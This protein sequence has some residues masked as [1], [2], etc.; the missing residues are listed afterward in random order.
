MKTDRFPLTLSQIDIYFNQLHNPDNPLYNV[1]GYIRLPA[2]DRIRLS[3]AHAS[4]VRSHDAFGVRISPDID[5]VSQY[6]SEVRT[7]KLQFLDLSAESNSIEAAQNYVND[8]FET[9]M[10][11]TE[12]ELFRAW[13]LK[14]A[15]DEYWYV[16]LAHHLCMDGFGFAN[17][18][19]ELGLLYDNEQNELRQPISIKEL[20]LDDISYMEG[21]RYKKDK[22]YWSAKKIDRKEDYFPIKP[23]VV[24]NKSIRS[25]RIT[26]RL[27]IQQVAQV[28]NLAE[29]LNVGIHVIYLS[30][31]AIYLGRMYGLREVIIGIPVH[32]RRGFAQKN[33]LGVMANITPLKVVVEL[34]QPFDS[35]VKY[36]SDLQKRDY[37]HQRYPMGHISRDS[38]VGHDIGGLYKSVFNYLAL[39]SELNIG[40]SDCELVYCPHNH[41]KNPLMFTLWRYAA[42]D[43]FVH[44]D[45]NH[46]YLSSAEIENLW[47]CLEQA[48]ISVSAND[49]LPLSEIEFLNAESLSIL[50][51]YSIAPKIPCNTFLEI[52][53]S[54]DY[55]AKNTPREIAV[56]SKGEQLTYEQL[57]IQSDMLASQLYE[58]GLKDNEAVG[59]CLSRDLTLPVA[60]L[61]VLKAGAAYVALD[62]AY[63]I[64]RL[65]YIVNDASIRFVISRPSISVVYQLG[66]DTILNP[67]DLDSK[68]A[69]S[70]DK[71]PAATYHLERSYKANNLAY[72]L[73]TSGSTGYPKGVLIEHKSVIALLEW[74][75]S[76]FS[77]NE[78]RDVLCS[79]SIN[80][81]LFVF[82]FWAALGTGNQLT[83]VDNLFDILEFTNLTPTLIN[84]VP[85]AIAAVV[86][87]TM[88]METVATVNI[89][90]EPLKRSLVNTLFERSRAS[91]ILNLYGPSEDTTYSTFAVF[92]NKLEVEP[93]IG[94]PIANGEA[95][96]I[97]NGGQ[98]CPVGV[99]GELFLSG[100]GLARGYLNKPDL[101]YEKFVDV[102]LLGQSRRCYKTGDLA[103]WNSDGQ[104]EFLG[105]VDHQVKIRGY[106]IELGDID[107]VLQR[108]DLVSDIV[109]VAVD[110]ASKLVTYFVPRSKVDSDYAIDAELRKLVEQYLPAYMMPAFFFRLNSLPLTPN[111][112][113]DRKALPA[114]DLSSS[115]GSTG[116]KPR[117][118][119]ENLIASSWSKVLGIPLDT[120][121]IDKDFFEAGGD[122]IIALQFVAKCK[123][124]GLQINLQDIFRRKTIRKLAALATKKQAFES[125]ASLPSEGEQQLLPIQ[126]LLFRD[127][128]HS[129]RSF[130]HYVTLK[131][132]VPVTLAKIKRIVNLLIGMHDVFRLDFVNDDK[133]WSSRYLPTEEIDVDSHIAFYQITPPLAGGDKRQRIAK[134]IKEQNHAVDLLR[135]NL[136]KFVLI[137][138]ARHS[139]LSIICHHLIVDGVSWRILT[140]DIEQILQNNELNDIVK[141]YQISTYQSWAELLWGDKSSAI[142]LAEKPYWISQLDSAIV[143]MHCAQP[144]RSTKHLSTRKHRWRMPLEQASSVFAVVFERFRCEAHHLLLAAILL[145]LHRWSSQSAFCVGL[146]SH[147]RNSL[148]DNEYE[149]STIVGWFTSFHKHVL[150]LPDC[151]QYEDVL[152]YTKEVLRK[153]PNGGIGYGVLTEIIKDEEFR[154]LDAETPVDLLFNYLGRMDQAFARSTEI[155]LDADLSGYY[156]D[157]QRNRDCLLGFN[158]M[159]AGGEL[160]FDID[161]SSEEFSEQDVKCIADEFSNVL[162]EFGSLGLAKDLPRYSPSDFPA[163]RVN[164]TQLDYWVEEYGN[165]SDI[166]PATKTQKGMLYHSS[167]DAGAYITQIV[168]RFSKDL[169]PALFKNAWND[170]VKKYAVFR[171]RFSVDY[172]NQIVL[173]EDDVCWEEVCD[174]SNSIAA[175][176]ILH[177]DKKSIEDGSITPLVRFTLVQK[178]DCWEFF[179]TFHHAILDGWSVALVLSDL[180]LFYRDYKNERVPKLTEKYSYKNI[181][182]WLNARSTADSVAYWKKQLNQFE[183]PSTFSFEKPIR[184]TSTAAISDEV[185]I[186]LNAEQGMVLAKFAKS[187]K[188]SLS[189]VYKAAWSILLARLGGDMCVSFGETHSGRNISIEGAESVVGLLL[190]TVPV[191]VDVQLSSSLES[192][193][194]CV[195]EDSL[196]RQEH[197]HLPLIDIMSC[198]PKPG[199]ALFDTVIVFENYPLDELLFEKNNELNILDFKAYESTHYGLTVQIYPGDSPEI[200]LKFNSSRYDALRMSQLLRYF[201]SLLRVFPNA[202][203]QSIG[204]IRYLEDELYQKILNTW[205]RGYSLNLIS[206]EKLDTHIYRL[207]E[208]HAETQPTLPA[209]VMGDTQVSYATLNARAN[210]VAHALIYQGIVPGQRVG[211]CAERSPDMIIGLLGVLKAGG[212]YVP[213]DPQYP[214]QRLQFMCEDADLSAVI[215]QRQLADHPALKPY[216]IIFVDEPAY[217]STYPES[218]P[219]VPVQAEGP[220]YII[221]TSGSTGTPKG[222]LLAH[223]GLTNLALQLRG[224]LNVGPQSRVLQF[225]SIS[226]DAATFEWTL[227]LC[228]GAQLHLVSAEAAATPALL[229]QAVASAQITHALLPPI[230]LPLL[231]RQAWAS[232][233]CLLIGGDTCPQVLADTWSDGRTLYNAYGPSEATVICTLGQYRAGQAEL[234]IGRP[235][236]LCQVYVLDERGH[237]VPE[238]VEGELYVGGVGVAMGYV[239]RPE[240]TAQRFVEP[241]VLDYL[242]ERLRSPLYR[243]GDR[244]KWLADGNLAYLGRVDNQV[245]IRGFRVEPSEVANHLIAA[246]F[247]DDAAVT[248]E[249]EGLNKHLACYVVPNR[250]AMSEWVLSEAKHS[251]VQN[252]KV[253]LAHAFPEY[254]IPT[255]Y[256]VLDCIPISPN[257]KLDRKALPEAD[258]LPA[259]DVFEAPETEIELEIA[260]LWSQLLEI[261]GDIDR[262]TSFFEIGGNSLSAAQIVGLINQ[263]LRVVISIKQFFEHPTIKLLGEQVCGSRP[264]ISQPISLVDRTQ[265]LKLSPAQQRLWLVDRISGGSPQYNIGASLEL[266]GV[267]DIAALEHSFRT[268]IQRHEVLRTVYQSNAVAQQI[269][270]SQRD[271]QPA[272]QCIRQD[273]EYR[274]GVTD[275]R[276]K[277]TS[278][279]EISVK[280]RIK[281]QLEQPFDLTDD[282]V[283]RTHF[284]WLEERFGILVFTVH[285][286]AA[287][288]WSINILAQ[289]FTQLYSNYVSGRVIELESLDIQY[290]DYAHWQASEYEN[291]DS[292]DYWLHTIQGVPP[293][294]SLPVT[295]VFGATGTSAAT[296]QQTVPK[297]SLLLL[298]RLSEREN[299]TL[300]TIL[301]TIFALTLARFAGVNDIVVGAPVANRERAELSRLVG[302][303]VNTV[304]LRNKINIDLSFIELL[305]NSRDMVVNALDHQ[306]VSFD[307][308]VEVLNPERVNTHAPLVQ[309]IFALQEDYGKHLS[310]PGIDISI[311]EYRNS[312]AKYDLILNVQRKSDILVASWEYRTDIFSKDLVERL[313]GYFSNLIGALSADIYAPIKSCILF[314]PSEPTGYELDDGFY[315]GEALA[316]L[317]RQ[318]SNLLWLADESHYPVPE[319]AYGEVIIDGRVNSCGHAHLLANAT[320]KLSVFTLPSDKTKQGY[321]TGLIGRI[322]EQG[323]LVLLCHKSSYVLMRGVRTCLDTLEECYTNDTP[324]VSARYIFT[325]SRPQPDSHQAPS[326]GHGV[327]PIVCIELVDS[328]ASDGFSEDKNL[329]LQELLLEIHQTVSRKLSPHCLPEGYVVG[330]WPDIHTEVHLD[331]PVNGSIIW[332]E[333]LKSF[334]PQNTTEIQLAEIWCDLLCCQIPG[335]NSH[336]FALGGN[337]LTLVRLEFAILEGFSVAV[338]IGELFSHPTL[339]EQARLIHEKEQL[340]ALPQIARL[341]QNVPAPLSYAQ[342]RL[343]FLDKMD[344]Q[345]AQ[346]NMPLALRIAGKLDSAAL[347]FALQQ[348][349]ERHE[350]LRT[351]YHSN[352]QGDPILHLRDSIA[353]TLR[354]EDVS[355]RESG[356]REAAVKA[357]IDADARRPFDLS[358]DLML[359]GALIK[360]GEDDHVLSLAV[361]HIAADGWSVG[362]ILDEFVALYQDA[363]EGRSPSIAPLKIQYSDFAHWQ[364]ELLADE[365]YLAPQLDYWKS[366][367]HGAPPVHG[368]PLDKPRPEVTTFNGAVHHQQ[369]ERQLKEQL[370][371]LCLASDSTLFMVLDAAFA[372]LLSRF[373]RESDIVIGTPIANRS[374]SDISEL[375]GFFVNTLV[376]RHTIDL[377]QSFRD[378]LADVRTLALEAYEHQHVPFEMLVESLDVT[379]S[380]RHSPVFQIM[381][382]LQNAESG[383]LTLPGLSITPLEQAHTVAKFDLTLSIKET[384]QGLSVAWEYNTDLFGPDTIAQL[385][386]SFDMLLQ[387]VVAN[388]DESVSRLNL[389]S[390][391]HAFKLLE[392]WSNNGIR[393]SHQ[394]DNAAFTSVYSRFSDVVISCPTAIAIIDNGRTTS[395]RELDD[396]ASVTA[397][398]IRQRELQHKS[399]IGVFCDRSVDMVAGILAILKSNATYVPLLP[400]LPD[401]R[402]E[403]IAKDADLDLV[404]IDKNNA[405][406]ALALFNNTLLINDARVQ[407]N[408]T[409]D[410]GRVLP[411]LT[412]QANDGLAYIIY[413]S[414]ST[415]VPKGV[416]I[417]HDNLSSYIEYAIE[418]YNPKKYT[419]VVSTSISF[420][421][422]VTSLL[423]PLFSGGTIELVSDQGNHEL[424]NLAALIQRADTPLL[425]KLTPAHLH[426]LEALLDGFS[427]EIP[428][429]LVVGGEQLYSKTLI[430]WRK[431]ILVTSTFVNEY[432]PTE[433]TVGCSTFFVAGDADLALLPLAVPIGKPIDSARLYV[434]DSELK[435]LPA[436]AI[437]ELYI[438][439]KGVSPGYVNRAELTSERFINIRLSDGN[440]QRAY[441]TGDLV[442]WG[443]DG[444]LQYQGRIDEQVKIRG[445]RIELGEVETVLRAMEIVD[446]AAVVARDEPS[447]LV[448]FVEPK[449]TDDKSTKNT[450]IL[451]RLRALLPSY[452]V[453]DIVVLMEH[454]P[455]T[456]NGKVDRIFL[457]QMEVEFASEVA[458]EAPHTEIEILLCE[459]C[460][461]LL[462]IKNIG[463]H[464]NFFALGGNSLL[465]IKLIARVNDQFQVSINVSDIF[466]LQT[467]Y[468]LAEWV[469]GEKKLNQALLETEET[470]I[471]GEEAWEI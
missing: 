459:L 395:Y 272:Y 97:D 158:G 142:F 88:L 462:S 372:V 131:I 284:I 254:M 266:S 434:L 263:N 24:D 13:L 430:F 411:A 325:E 444:N 25:G 49:A 211:L 74:V 170:I 221:Y 16:G 193:L 196:I 120:V 44:L 65:K 164:Q 161:Y 265:P 17:W 308:I 163:A 212:A 127:E 118:S 57:G 432:G 32:N 217:A 5:G 321:A 291:A 61:A 300:F 286:I 204:D 70:G 322:S 469:D 250:I 82:E 195:H 262:N 399:R 404:V 98:L 147:G 132:D 238:G 439:G 237:P 400:D 154:I 418:T 18:A 177:R 179:W 425:L 376:L 412:K 463:I 436:G 370:N 359:R 201:V 343:W 438:V 199:T 56:K 242:D 109:T 278:A 167:V 146:E 417:T 360:V 329:A 407:P 304:V 26:K 365:K 93:T 383:D 458:Y 184:T 151:C 326:E 53:Q 77:Q 6:I 47:A 331:D 316:S 23:V 452:M 244:V 413:T 106:R 3:E 157:P 14:I 103:R 226:F 58:L 264:S 327:I 423:V 71:D 437:G 433:A 450:E 390:E 336:F 352:S 139:Y 188:V 84:T 245:K 123:E 293:I 152:L 339:S 312:L 230:L 104:L 156:V 346:Y 7:H 228:S 227:A 15:E 298:E 92:E 1:G 344:G 4:L 162:F 435:L 219:N 281:Q 275:L 153:I 408:D 457:R 10:P 255:H 269:S 274:M 420:D 315:P 287:D 357:Y 314:Q 341:P 402:L 324:A 190:N 174:R 94:K 447:R 470:T 394:E 243:T 159:I 207:F 76:A 155:S 206:A 169:H 119:R 205:G 166:Y 214:V 31:F 358:R 337:S 369:L 48:S 260:A 426:A 208:K 112:K 261:D 393:F 83:L 364:R 45:Y 128:V 80:F 29:K 55:W 356:E 296:Y 90:G 332:L 46:Q 185:S 108:S 391:S 63:P 60:I 468:E 200:C 2:V 385:A 355:L 367:L 66:V 454:L 160:F 239:N 267:I 465:A 115:L 373:S 410:E 371:A 323:K 334:P 165:I 310:M 414:G 225:A 456:A 443:A 305:H 409:L 189:S 62:P 137:D 270:I 8:F 258:V 449:S 381:F 318:C 218:N 114:V 126:S 451:K 349:I 428:H 117:T 34:S 135:K 406:R 54:F 276:G 192:F 294:H 345:S 301:Q 42:G 124:S 299:I 455:L 148:L 89:A 37:R 107:S 446:D 145:S 140:S 422:T 181:I 466:R 401:A 182:L 350:V 283:V 78:L 384:A 38:G 223:R 95:F 52:Q 388:P 379:R 307:K 460:C 251:F 386:N 309:V 268:I 246:D 353:F 235:L 224:Q 431:H 203:D 289:E 20:V 69:R 134:V 338:S 328:V 361:H 351:S 397:S 313:G 91:R 241:A 129:I 429:L 277:N 374:H 125:A 464:D 396:L 333:Q 398:R 116:E 471:E 198:S 141:N 35:F 256:A 197:S 191:I 382:V 143:R 102:A 306:Q 183:H 424:E 87:K 79:T 405:E 121:D 441:R 178:G 392:Q 59:I 75:K 335:R 403:F 175:D 290:A 453:P 220:A 232:V 271:M 130:N 180:Y 186:R 282:L 362:L 85:S 122:S 50:K 421:A 19:K 317:L 33:M 171:T 138:D 249:G 342:Q 216:N 149:P 194:R 133:G 253:E 377:G 150:R 259:N 86:E 240:L 288:G 73:Y 209:L 368:L 442:R 340:A 375:I 215:C 363:V 41:E 101:N 111:G 354:L 213:L 273:F 330:A 11:F 67:D 100:T 22:E 461:E 229:D 81:D 99:T 36:V 387:H 252:V 72:I 415:G 113:I 136:F 248:V 378:F 257:G 448:A 231:D 68:P 440:P 279:E 297:E 295:K 64:D 445:Y 202:V 302:F 234:H 12:S 9:P 427:S 348:V 176:T 347:Q 311:N 27:D 39:D 389:V 236:G 303:F 168:L 280:T 416:G 144:G 28:Q 105:R 30:L 319:G 292:L 210:Q 380:S 110:E 247:I 187:A 366:R 467:V 285:H 233:T 222:A 172:L 173:L 51:K 96:V 21:A 40:G 419:S 320:N 43:V